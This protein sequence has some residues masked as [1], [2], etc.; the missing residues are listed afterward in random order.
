ME[1]AP[2]AAPAS[3][4]PS[5]SPTGPARSPSSSRSRSRSPPRRNRP[6]TPPPARVRPTRAVVPE[7]V[8]RKRVHRGCRSGAQARARRELSGSESPPPARPPPPQSSSPFGVPIRLDSNQSP[9]S[10][11]P[12][13]SPFLAFSPVRPVPGPSPFLAQP[14]PQLLPPWLHHCR[15]PA[16]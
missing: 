12:A 3:P 16:R 10:T 15:G 5:R 9:F 13:V 11:R 6:P 2:D 7:R 14:V 4:T 1:R 8:R